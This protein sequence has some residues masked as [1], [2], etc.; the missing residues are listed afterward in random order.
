MT[1]KTVTTD[2]DSSGVAKVK[3]ESADAEEAVDEA[4]EAASDE[5]AETDEAAVESAD[6]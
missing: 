3:K 1:D 6:A 2:N 5:A 4:A